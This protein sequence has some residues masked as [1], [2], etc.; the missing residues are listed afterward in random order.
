MRRQLRREGAKPHCPPPL[1]AVLLWG[2]LR[3]RLQHPHRCV[4]MQS[5]ASEQTDDQ[6]ALDLAT[7]PVPQQQRRTTGWCCSTKA[8]PSPISPLTQPSH[9]HTCSPLACLVQKMPTRPLLVHL[10][11]PH[12]CHRFC[13][14]RTCHR[15]RQPQTN[16]SS[17][18]RVQHSSLMYGPFHVRSA[19]STA[20][21]IHVRSA[22]STASA[23]RVV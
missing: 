10:P 3:L 6:P 17:L 22:H 8:E 9:R 19:H 5:R 21:A 1:P 14:T 12:M 23:S 4:S 20:G 11:K 2:N 15:F 18:S 13:Q 16:G 7:A